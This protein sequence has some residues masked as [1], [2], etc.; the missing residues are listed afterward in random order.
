MV[1]NCT[2]YGVDEVEAVEDLD[3]PAM[4]RRSEQ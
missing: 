1:G 2:E 4:S 3:A